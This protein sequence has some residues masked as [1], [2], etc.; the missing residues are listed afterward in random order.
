M[1]YGHNVYDG[2]KENLYGH[3]FL[4]EQNCHKRRATPRILTR[5]GLGQVESREAEDVFESDV[6][7]CSHIQNLRVDCVP[8]SEHKM[9]S[10]EESTPAFGRVFVRRKH[11]EPIANLH[12]VGAMKN[13][14]SRSR[15]A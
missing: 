4:R 2:R 3:G 11:S 7:K 9:P 6:A 1:G 12:S 10:G 5:P 15:Q 8:P 14:G 13:A